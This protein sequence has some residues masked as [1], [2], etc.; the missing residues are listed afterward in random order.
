MGCCRQS[1]ASESVM[2]ALLTLFL[3]DTT[4]NFPGVPI[5]FFRERL[6]RSRHLF[7]W[8]AERFDAA[9]L[10]RQLVGTMAQ[11]SDIAHQLG[12]LWDWLW[13]ARL[14]RADDG[15]VAV[16]EHMVRPVD[17]DHVDFVIAATQ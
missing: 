11:D 9:G 2:P 1:G 16:D 8:L 15:E 13:P 7:P 5:S 4:L 10:L 6:T 3:I 17:S 12:H 14:L